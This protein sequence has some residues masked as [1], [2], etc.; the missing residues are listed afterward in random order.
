MTIGINWAEIWDESIWD[1]IWA[2]AEGGPPSDTTPNPFTFVDQSGV[3]R[4]TTIISNSITVSG[5]NAPAAIS[6]LNGAY[7]INGSGVFVT[8]PGMVSNGNTVRVSHTSSANYLSIVTSVLTIGG[9]LDTFTSQTLAEPVAP[10][11]TVRT[12]RSRTVYIGRW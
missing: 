1:A 6:V 5:I 11:I 2:P 3:A 10:Q 9:V 4:A 8:T 12:P 7:E